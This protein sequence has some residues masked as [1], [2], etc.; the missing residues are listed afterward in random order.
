MLAFV[1][2]VITANVVTTVFMV[3][4]VPTVTKATLGFPTVKCP[5]VIFLYY[6]QSRFVFESS[7]VFFNLLRLR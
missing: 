5:L 7:S 6:K 2:T 1:K 4:T 3:T